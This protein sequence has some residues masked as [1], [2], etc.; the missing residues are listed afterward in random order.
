MTNLS[1]QK[2]ES[3]DQ[4][5]VVGYY[6]KHVSDFHKRISEESHGNEVHEDS[7]REEN[8]RFLEQAITLRQGLDEEKKYR[9]S[10]TYLLEI[11][12]GR[13]FRLLSFELSS[14]N[15]LFTADEL[16][17]AANAVLGIGNAWFSPKSLAK[18]FAEENGLDSLEG[19]SP[20]VQLAKKLWELTPL[21]NAALQDIC[22]RFFVTRMED[23]ESFRSVISRLGL[24]L[25]D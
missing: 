13:Y 7:R 10:S 14:L 6:T 15:G 8:V 2:V 23:G 18:M 3:K 22:E 16:L 5:D 12:A 1:S 24:E 17:Q 11:A 9:Y 25:A 20:Q 4:K 19:S 21:Q